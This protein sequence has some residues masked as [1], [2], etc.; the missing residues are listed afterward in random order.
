V[1][2]KYLIFAAVFLGAIQNRPNPFSEISGAWE[3]DLPASSNENVRLLVIR[4]STG[5]A[6]DGLIDH[7][8]VLRPLEGR[9]QRTFRVHVGTDTNG[10]LT[11]SSDGASLYVGFPGERAADTDSIRFV[12][13]SGIDSTGAPTDETVIRR[14]ASR[15]AIRRIIGAFQLIQSE[16][17][18]DRIQPGDSASLHQAMQETRERIRTQVY[19]I[20]RLPVRRVDP[21]V[22]GLRDSVVSVANAFDL[23]TQNLEKLLDRRLIAK[24][25]EPYPDG[26][27][28]DLLALLS[29]R[30]DESMGKQAAIDGELAVF[31]RHGR[32]HQTRM[33]AV[34]LQS[35][36]VRASLNNRLAVP[37]QPAPF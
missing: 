35:I 5:V 14:T 28:E 17:P 34:R 29:G 22:V 3:A 6:T 25:I 37:G 31:V 16:R 11:L 20:A 18:F 1:Q 13:R 23:Y 30:V 10:V 27:W 36:A 4:D 24:A 32:L 2:Y 7:A 19:S 15:T 12:R 33:E 8:I 9:A 26:F 21:E